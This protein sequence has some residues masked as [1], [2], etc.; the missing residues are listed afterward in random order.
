MKILEIS[1]NIPRAEVEEWTDI[2]RI[3]VRPKRGVIKILFQN[4]F[5]AQIDQQ[6]GK[7]LQIAKR[8]SE[9]IEAIHEGKFF[10]KNASYAIFAPAAVIL[11][12]LIITGVYLFISIFLRKGKAKSLNKREG[13]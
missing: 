13:C 12:I 1:K 8:N 10:H 6:N 7:I 5:E 11:L 3:D 9:L 4:N 2:K